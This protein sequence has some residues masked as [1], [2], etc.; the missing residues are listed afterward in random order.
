MEQLFHLIN[1]NQTR[2][3]MHAVSVTK[4]HKSTNNKM[5]TEG[6]LPPNDKQTV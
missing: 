1:S 2:V 3:I 4:N 6:N 5:F